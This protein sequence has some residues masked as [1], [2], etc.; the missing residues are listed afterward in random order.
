LLAAELNSLSAK[1]RSAALE[2]VHCV[3]EELAETAEKIEKSLAEF[4]HAVQE[5]KNELYDIAV[6]MNRSYVEDPLFRLKF[7]RANMHDVKRSVRQMMNLLRYKA[8]Y[9]GN[10][11]IAREITL[12][13]LT[14]EDMKLMLSG[15]FHIQDGRDRTG[16]VIIYLNNTL[17]GQCKADS[18][19]RVAYYI[20]FNILIPIP[21]VQMKGLVGVYYDIA[22]PGEKIAMPGFNF[23]LTILDFTISLPMRY[24]AMHFGLKPEKGNHALNSA[25]L[26]I[27]M[28][29]LPQ[30]A[31]VRSRL[32]YGSDLEL[33]YQFQSHGL[34]IDTC[35]VDNNGN[36]RKDI[37]NAWF[38]KHKAQSGTNSKWFYNRGPSP[39]MHTSAGE[40]STC[41]VE[42]EELDSFFVDQC[43][44]GFAET[45]KISPA[46]IPMDI[47][48]ELMSVEQQQR[49]HEEVAHPVTANG[50][51]PSR[52]DVLLGRGRGIQSH[53]GNVKFRK[54]LEDY[55]NEYDQA[56]RGKRRKIAAELSQVF[57]VKG[58]RFLEQKNN[59]WV[60]SD[61]ADAEKKIAQLFRTLRKKKVKD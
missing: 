23:M 37:M 40:V 56:R 41:T 42:T 3:G 50:I 35:P 26:G 22:K 57:G 15:L 18:L 19:I 51:I 39:L 4:E 12:D 34:P 45:E 29:I 27:A 36:I 20:W 43:M 5:E 14:E 1:E 2:D 59:R 7:L 21:E 13:D 58:V 16:R 17:L 47:E 49:Q 25:V 54:F 24:T 60:E 52:N 48:D 28:N 55:S 8:T 9:F 46:V 53:P 61:H 11:K 31:R 33:H 44:P 30:Y 6:K 38:Y 32:H 10:D